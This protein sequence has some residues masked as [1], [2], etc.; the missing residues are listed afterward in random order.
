MINSGPA[1]TDQIK[2]AILAPK[3]P[4]SKR[5]SL[6]IRSAVVQLPHTVDPIQGGMSHPTG[7]W[8]ES[9]TADGYVD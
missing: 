4:V 7:L 9:I 1:T 3:L 8:F 5:G 2:N 6:M